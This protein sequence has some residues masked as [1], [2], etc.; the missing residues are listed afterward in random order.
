[1]QDNKNMSMNKQESVE[2]NPREGAEKNIKFNDQ[3]DSKLKVGQRLLNP[4]YVIGL[5]VFAAIIIAVI[6]VIAIALGGD[7]EEPNAPTD[8]ITGEE[9]EPTTP[10]PVEPDYPAGDVVTYSRGFVYTLSDDGSYY[11][12]SAIGTCKDTKINIPPQYQG[13]PVKEIGNK[14]FEYCEKVKSITIPD[15][16]IKIGTAAF[17]G[18]LSLQTLK[19]PDTIT[20]IGYDA[21]LSCLRLSKFTYG[22]FSYLGTDTNPFFYLIDGV[23]AKS[24]AI[25]SDTRV[26]C[27]GAFTERT[28]IT[29]LEIPEGVIAI[30]DGAFGGCTNLTSVTIPESVKHIGE[31]VFYGCTSL[32]SVTLPNSLDQIPANAF[33]GCESLVYNE[34]DNGLYLGSL[35]NPYLLLVCAKNAEIISCVIHPDTK[36]IADRAFNKC[37]AMTSV[38]IP[39]GLRSIGS[40]AFNLCAVLRDVYF[41]GTA[42]E[43]EKIEIGRSNSYFE[44]A[45]LY[46]EPQQ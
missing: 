30:N 42:E 6:I 27:A 31:M 45:T 21:F 35:E 3:T 8:E 46:T 19:L 4:Q 32:E 44:R 37:R 36:I 40:G 11:I 29:K 23:N 24:P 39:V 15:T 25:D 41:T 10:T 7:G 16:V 33:D 2:V 43:F 12:L 1:M 17:A 14:A 13:K 9:G 20:Y 38:T 34:F 18:C 22:G 28:V 26:I 5:I